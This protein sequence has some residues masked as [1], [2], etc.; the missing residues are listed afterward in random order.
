VSAREP[1]PRQA[2]ERA[3]SND[4]MELV[5]DSTGTSMQVAAVLMLETARIPV[6]RR[7]K[8]GNDE[9]Q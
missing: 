8:S 9:T 2:V 1:A 3:S 4:V 5:C 7:R 6:E